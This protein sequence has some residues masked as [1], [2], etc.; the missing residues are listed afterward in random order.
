MQ[1]KL[2]SPSLGLLEGCVYAELEVS[3][4]SLG[5]SEVLRKNNGMGLPILDSLQMFLAFIDN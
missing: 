1:G 5:D 4:P 3:L 2:I